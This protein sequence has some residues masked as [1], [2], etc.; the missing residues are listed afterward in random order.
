MLFGEHEIL[1]KTA[2]LN[3]IKVYLA[4]T[5]VTNIRFDERFTASGHDIKEAKAL[6]HD[7]IY[8]FAM[9]EGYIPS[10]GEVEALLKEAEGE[11]YALFKRIDTA[12]DKV[13][14]Y[15]LDYENISQEQCRDILREL[16]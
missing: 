2:L 12:L 9:S 7:M 13:A 10:E 3:R 6:A 8:N 5:V 16:F 4:G 11:L 14:A 1:S 15:L